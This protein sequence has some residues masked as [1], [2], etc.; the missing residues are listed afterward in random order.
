[1]N[2]YSIDENAPVLLVQ[3]GK[4]IMELETISLNISLNK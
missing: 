4:V 3:D 1:M 2:K